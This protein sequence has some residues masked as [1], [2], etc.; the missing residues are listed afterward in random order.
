[1]TPPG[2]LVKGEIVR[3]SS[4]GNAIIRTNAG[5]YSV[6]STVT[7]DIGTSVVGRVLTSNWAILSGWATNDDAEKQGWDSEGWVQ[8]T[9][10]VEKGGMLGVGVSD[11]IA[12]EIFF[13]GE[14]SCTIGTHLPIIPVVPEYTVDGMRRGFCTDPQ[15]W[16]SDYVVSL[17]NTTNISITQFT[18]IEDRIQNPDSNLSEYDFLEVTDTH[19]HNKG[20]RITIDD[21]GGSRDIPT[22]RELVD[23]ATSHKL[24]V[25]DRDVADALG[26][27]GE[28]YA[29]V[30]RVSNEGRALGTV[31]TQRGNSEE[32]IFGKL[33]CEPGD[34]IPVLPLAG[35]HHWQRPAVCTSIELWAQESYIHTFHEYSTALT[36]EDSRNLGEAIIR[37][38][39]HPGL[40]Y[41]ISESDGVATHFI[42]DISVDD[43][44]TNGDSETADDVVDG[45]NA[46]SSHSH[47]DTTS[48]ASEEQEIVHKDCASAG[49]T[50]EPLPGS[51][52]QD[53]VGDV[54]SNV[55]EKDEQSRASDDIIAEQTDPALTEDNVEYTESRRRV[56][57]A[58]FTENVRE[59]Y[60]ERCAVCSARRVA[61]D[62]STEVE[63]AHIYPKSE[64]GPDVVQNG[65][66]LCRL[67]HWAF[68]AGWISFTDNNDIIVR[69]VPDR[70]G[71][72]EF[73]D[74]DGK[75][76][77]LPDDEGLR[78]HPKFIREHR[79][80]HGFDC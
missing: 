18:G 44:R 48:V 56:R 61:P 65:I 72:E 40:V 45:A 67:H 29:V 53:A 63:A 79:T 58:S 30:D 49:E 59:A 74:F 50:Q 9:K 70:D 37:Q 69:D 7:Q 68:D 20:P 73:A 60:D 64:G 33:K 66:A 23:T 4:Q 27:D 34:I 8:V 25:D 31:T 13:L 41:S 57:D 19:S 22:P 24:D 54:A 14:L 12:G 80:L 55:D 16:P 78:P 42:N 76:L 62:G 77:H 2:T 75:T 28:I 1:M 47:E 39:A 3:N 32:L 6:H 36:E 11:A 46:A 43:A 17:A 51:K 10:I 71:Y 5:E 52:Q 35:K 15:L 38:T 26:F 21:V